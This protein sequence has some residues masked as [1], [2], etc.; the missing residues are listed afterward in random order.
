[1]NNNNPP[2]LRRRRESK[3]E[4]ENLQYFIHSFNPLFTTTLK[5]FTKK[6]VRIIKEIIAAQDAVDKLKKAL[7]KKIPPKSLVPNITISLPLSYENECKA[8]KKIYDDAALT[9]TTKMLN[10]RQQIVTAK[11]KQSDNIKDQT[12]NDI[13]TFTQ[14]QAVP[15]S[16]RDELTAHFQQLAKAHFVSLT[17]KLKFQ[18]TRKREAKAEK[19][20]EKKVHEQKEQLENKDDPLPTVKA[21][22]DKKLNE[23]NLLAKNHQQNLQ[24]PQQSNRHFQPQRHNA[25]PRQNFLGRNNNRFINSRSFNP[26]RSYNARRNMSHHRFNWR[27]NTHQRNHPQVQRLVRRTVH[28]S[29]PKNFYQRSAPPRRKYLNQRT[30]ST[31]WYQRK[32]P[33]QNDN[34]TPNNNRKSPQQKPKNFQHSARKPPSS[35]RLRLT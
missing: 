22:I 28:K 1:M 15:E 3:D 20:K 12:L 18:E 27:A 26:Q 33:L 6:Y 9:A 11:L 35:R 5:L 13:L 30:K 7:D 21:Y 14:S 10:I 16:T 23:M 17:S 34:A 24:R 25:R 4:D 32:A 2:R 31:P 8:L 29:K 19:E